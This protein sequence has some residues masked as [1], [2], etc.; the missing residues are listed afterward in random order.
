MPRWRISCAHISISSPSG[1]HSACRR[2]GA[3]R[4]MATD[5]GQW[6]APGGRAKAQRG[7]VATAFASAARCASPRPPVALLQPRGEHEEGIAAMSLA[8][9]S[10]PL[11]ALLDLLI[12]DPR[13]WPHPVR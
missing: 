11:G 3:H 7:P 2:A 5:C 8:A 9:W 6:A 1:L 13:G 4:E 12:G 10:L